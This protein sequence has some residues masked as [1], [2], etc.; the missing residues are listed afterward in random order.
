MVRTPA[1][2]RSLAAVLLLVATGSAAMAGDY[3]TFQVGDWQ[4]RAH[5]SDDTGAFTHCAISADFPEHSFLTFGISRENVFAIFFGDTGW[6]LADRHRYQ[7]KLVV[8]GKSLGE[9][10]ADATGGITLGVRIGT[11][12]AAFDALRKGKKLTIKTPQREFTFALKKSARALRKL[13]ECVEK[14]TAQATGES[15]SPA[16]PQ[17]KG[18]DIYTRDEVARILFKAGIRQP[19]FLSPEQV[20]RYP[21]FRQMWSAGPVVG[22]V[23]QFL[24][25]PAVS[26][27]E[28]MALFL[29]NFA[30][31]CA[32]N[33]DSGAQPAKTRGAYVFKE[34]HVSCAGTHVFYMRA[35]ALFEAQRLSI[36]GY[37]GWS[38]ESRVA[39]E[40]AT[41]T[42]ADALYQLYF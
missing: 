10:P 13:Q 20:A 27:D 15:D 34:G 35:V 9:F 29:S 42:L 38:T 16:A 32:G 1:I 7:V 31:G 41:A 19:E 12:R 37:M 8:D 3:D 30:D 17:A 39:A 23:A 2:V 21:G 22:F 28:Q 26:V 14:E 36:F 40:A 11:S 24:R 33:V 4:G 5:R 25:N 18:P 6:H